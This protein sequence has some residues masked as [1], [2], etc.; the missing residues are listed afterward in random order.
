MLVRV[1]SG[2]TGVLISQGTAGAVYSALKRGWWGWCGDDSPLEDGEAPRKQFYPRR[3]E[4]MA[5]ECQSFSSRLSLSLKPPHPTPFSFSSQGL[6]VFA[7][8]GISR[9]PTG[10]LG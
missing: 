5:F 8:E 2:D 7:G 3:E 10:G 9:D 4:K 6:L 1:S